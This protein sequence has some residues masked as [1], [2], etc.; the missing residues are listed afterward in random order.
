MKFSLP[1]D[2]LTF[3]NA[4]LAG[5]EA[6]ASTELALAIPGEYTRYTFAVKHCLAQFAIENDCRAIYTFSG[7]A[8]FMLDLVWWQN[9]TPSKALLACESEWGNTRDVKHNAARVAEDFDKLLSFKAPFK[10]MI[11]EADPNSVNESETI[12]ELNRYLAEYADHRKGEQY[13]VINLQKHPAAWLCQIAADGPNAQLSL[14]PL[15]L[16]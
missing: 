3:A 11:F 2:P 7:M 14:A 5:I 12:D 10:L 16:T 6:I 8:E 1:L 4:F 9:K 15:T 13:L